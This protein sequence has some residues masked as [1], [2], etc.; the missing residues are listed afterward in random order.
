MVPDGPWF[1]CVRWADGRLDEG[2]WGARQTFWRERRRFAASNPSSQPL[3]G[4]DATSFFPSIPHDS[5]TCKQTH[6][7]TNICGLVVWVPNCGKAIAAICCVDLRISLLEH[8]RRSQ[9]GN[10]EKKEMRGK[11]ILLFSLL[12]F[13]LYEKSTRDDIFILVFKMPDM[14]QNDFIMLLDKPS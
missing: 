9:E 14:R 1:R 11:L 13:S 4:R 3:M 8:S 2:R 6:T 5:S 7:H 12:N 10:N